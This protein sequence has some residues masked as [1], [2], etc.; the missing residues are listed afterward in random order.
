ML[1]KNSLPIIFVKS[2]FTLTDTLFVQPST[3][4][5]RTTRDLHE[6]KVSRYMSEST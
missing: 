2:G 6:A 3:P 4:I 5:K 1:H